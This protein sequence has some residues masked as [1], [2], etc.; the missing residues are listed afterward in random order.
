MKVLDTSQLHASSTTAVGI[1]QMAATLSHELRTPLNAIVGSISLLE[2]RF[3]EGSH[4]RVHV[5]RLKRNSRHLVAM[6]DDVMELLGAHSGQLTVSR[7]RQP[8]RIVIHEALADVEVHASDRGVATVNRA[9]GV[10]EGPTYWG[11]ERRVHQIVVNLLTNAIKFTAPGGRVTISAGT[12]EV[13]AESIADRG[14]WA[15]IRVD[16][17]GRGIPPS[18]TASVFEPFHQVEPRDRNCGHGLGLAI[19]RQLARS[20]DGD[21]TLSSEVGVGSTFTL[22]LPTDSHGSR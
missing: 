11:D 13:N 7:A 16:D 8:L 2:R 9:P 19:C 17:T 12:S 22:W 15:F 20:M 3:P 5:D 14:P 18:H 10:D 4:D 1:R 6:L 21:I